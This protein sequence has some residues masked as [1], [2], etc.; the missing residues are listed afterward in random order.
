[1]QKG[2]DGVDVKH[3]FCTR[4]CPDKYKERETRYSSR[5]KTQTLD[6]MDLPSVPQT[7][8]KPT[9]INFLVLGIN[10]TDEEWANWRNQLLGLTEY[11]KVHIMFYRHGEL[12][13][14]ERQRYL[15]DCEI[16]TILCGEACKNAKFV[17]EDLTQIRNEIEGHVV[18]P[19]DEYLHD[20]MKRVE[21]VFQ[22][23]VVGNCDL[24]EPMAVTDGIKMD[25]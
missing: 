7:H 22:S 23:H 2:L 9:L 6:N 14:P 21:D 20:F 17:N 18:L 13:T 11:Y 16:V 10:Q 1:M 12:D 3:N 15:K 25:N 8:F 5:L 4:L 19:Y 24:C